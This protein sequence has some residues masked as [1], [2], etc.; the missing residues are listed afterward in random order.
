GAQI[1]QIPF[2]HF[3]RK[4]FPE[5]KIIG[6]APEK[7]SYVLKQYGYLDEEW[8]YPVKGNVLSLIKLAW[9]A[10]QYQPAIV[11]QHR[12]HSLK[13]SFS[14]WLAAGRGIKVKGFKGDLTRLFFT[15]EIPFNFN[16]YMADVYLSLIGKQLKQ[17][18]DEINPTSPKKE[19]KITIIPGGSFEYKKYPLKQYL[20]VAQQFEK[21]Y[22]IDFILGPD[23][24]EEFDT[25]KSLADRYHIHFNKSLKD[26]EQVIRTS[27][28]VIANDCGPSHFAH[29]FN[30]PRITLFAADWDVKQ[31]F[32]PSEN[33]R[34]LYSESREE[35]HTIPVG[36]I[37]N[38]AEELLG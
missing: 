27:S 25:L 2:F 33:S 23:M 36:D 22:Q 11:F 18:H 17:F 5:H 30:I 20:E 4:E 16:V 29:V 9:K 12:K 38:A 15:W 21:D 7:S 13:T 19:K 37:V 26:V 6:I 3:I 1:V 24:Q 34:Y 35:I 31:W 8:S 32:Y 10:R 14:A 28:L